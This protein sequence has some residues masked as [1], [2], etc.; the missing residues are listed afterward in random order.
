[1]AI[2][3]AF[4]RLSEGLVHY[5]FR[6]GEDQAKTPL[7]M[8]HAGPVSSASLEPLMDVIPGERALF[9]PDTLGYGD[10]AA[11]S[12][13]DPDIAYY[14]DSV[15]RFLDMAGL[16]RVDVFGTHTGAY[17]GCELAIA[18]KARVRRLVLEG[19]HLFQDDF[20]QTL[21]E[22][23]APTKTPDAYG[24]QFN[25][26]WQF[27]RDQ[28]LYFPYFDR[29]AENRLDSAMMA[30]DMLHAYVVDVLKALTTYHQG[31]RAVFRHNMKERLPLVTQPILVFH[32]EG[33]PQGKYAERP[34]SFI[35]ECNS[36]EIDA[37]TDASKKAALMESFLN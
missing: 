4:I 19:F 36:V 16:E 27:L 23:Y 34:E 3:R 10:S 18:H 32:L 6:A 2:D 11:P 29:S 28:M 1:M 26:A 30:P 9:A 13:Q 15:V 20:R 24:S 14:A 35:Q 12:R 8:L 33:D 17:I 22:H 31:Y 37:Y 5:R 21:L 25:W 7:L